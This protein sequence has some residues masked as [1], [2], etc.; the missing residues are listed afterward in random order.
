[1]VYEKGNTSPTGASQVEEQVVVD[2][3]FNCTK[4]EVA[5]ARDVFVGSS[6]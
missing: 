5:T 1:M 3:T 4:A 6:T 2:Q